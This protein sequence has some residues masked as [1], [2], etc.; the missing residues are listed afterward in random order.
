[1]A[2]P[3]S[4][5][6]SVDMPVTT[7]HSQYL[8]GKTLERDSSSKTTGKGLETA[9]PPFC[10]F[11]LFLHGLDGGPARTP[12]TNPRSHALELLLQDIGDVKA[13]AE[14]EK[15]VEEHHG[16]PVRS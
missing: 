12:K 1:M 7:A 10:Q 8:G 9:M 11:S 3:G 13:G 16:K 4:C 5:I 2:C 14:G 15:A 6:S